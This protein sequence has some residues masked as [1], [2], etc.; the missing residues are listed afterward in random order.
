MEKAIL[1][2]EGIQINDKTIETD[3]NIT[4]DL[5]GMG[6]GFT[7]DRV[8]DNL[9]EDNISE[10]VIALSGDIR[11]L[12]ICTFQLQ[13]PFSEERTFAQLTAKIPQLSISTS[14][15]YRRYVKNK[16][17][18]HLINP[19][20]GKPGK[21][22]VSVSL[23]TQAD[24][25][26]IDAYATAISVMPKEKALLFLEKH[27][28]I[29]FILVDNSAK[30]FYG[31]LE[32]FVRLRWLDYKEKTNMER[33]NKKS[34]TNRAMEINLIHPDTTNPQMIKR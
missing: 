4:I 33:S 31:N 30:I 7:V 19:K 6:K 16:M 8:V 3:A 27:Q 5:G 13:S 24:N 18:H 23:F 17:H 12:D 25:S 29:G 9:I 22:F 20:V 1:N 15:I 10:G 26:K 32:K 34:K 11:C 21:S 28:D 2:I 14:G